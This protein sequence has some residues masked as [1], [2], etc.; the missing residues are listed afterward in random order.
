MINFLPFYCNDF[1]ELK[2]TLVSFNQFSQDD[3]RYFINPFIEIIENEL[4]FYYDYWDKLH[5]SNKVFFFFLEEYIKKEM[6]KFNYIFEYYNK[7]SIAYMSY[8]MTRNGRGFHIDGCFSA[9]VP[10]PKNNE[11]FQS[12]FF[13]LLHEYTHQFTDNLLNTNINFADG[14]HNLSEYAVILSD[15]Y[16]LKAI[17]ES[18]VPNY[19]KMFTNNNSESETEF[20]NTYKVGQN[21]EEKIK[22]LTGNILKK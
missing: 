4:A 1:N 12:S 15:Y 2:N 18:M 19:I 3:M 5:N 20:M 16:L 8:S 9:A 10:F 7:S 14:S 11:S 6:E 17:D 13:T 22:E 21:L